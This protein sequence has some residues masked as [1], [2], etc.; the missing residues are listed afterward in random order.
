MNFKLF[1]RRIV[2]AYA[3]Y[4]IRLTL[5]TELIPCPICHSNDFE[6]LLERDRYNLPMRTVKCSKCGLVFEN[7]IPTV[8][9]LDHFYTSHLY[10]AL[11]W[12]VINPSADIISEFN[13]NERSRKHINLLKKIIAQDL[14]NIPMSLLDIGSSEG[15]F[16]K[17]FK[18]EFSKASISAV[19]PGRRFNSMTA[20]EIKVY[21]DIKAIPKDKKFDLITLWHVFEHIRDPISF[22]HSTGLHLHKNGTLII[23]VPDLERHKGIRPFHIDDLYH[24]SEKTLISLARKMNFDPV[25][26]TRD[27]NELMD[28][29]YGMAI[30]FR[31]N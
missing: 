29:H 5:E 27:S 6:V 11:D 31:K 13:A 24:Y 23:E 8:K 7:P 25:Y 26:I 18:K 17:E 4:R 21:E 16:V 14:M 19:E 30:V 22:I 10:R 20:P 3:K 15:S 28:P 9:F 2:R 12:G 1:K